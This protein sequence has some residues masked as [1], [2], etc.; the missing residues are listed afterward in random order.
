MDQFLAS[1]VDITHE[2]SLFPSLTLPRTDLVPEPEELMY[3][4]WDNSCLSGG[5]SGVSDDMELSP[6]PHS[7]EFDE[8]SA[9]ESKKMSHDTLVALVKFLP[10]KRR[11]I[12]EK[13]S[14]EGTEELVLDAVGDGIPSYD[15]NQL[16]KSNKRKRR[17]IIQKG[18]TE[19]TEEVVLDAVGD[20]IPSY[21]VNR[22]ERS[23]KRHATIAISLVEREPAT[24]PD[25]ALLQALLLTGQSSAAVELLKG[26]N[27]C[28]V[29]ICEV[30]LQNR[31]H[32]TAL[33]QLY[34]SDPMHREALKLLHHLVEESK[35]NESKAGPTLKFS[36]R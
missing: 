26:L 2:L 22:F 8:H 30:V 31:S 35:S 13:G 16:E 29:K 10:K 6:P 18:P 5:S 36:E 19:G 25:T 15:I 24:K 7:L 11:G 28:D 9:L 33:L 17:S 14:T 32:C 34:R 27:Y 1:E 12:I 20:G 23:N 4:S 3:T 21:D